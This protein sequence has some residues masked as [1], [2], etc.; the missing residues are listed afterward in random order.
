MTSGLRPVFAL[1]LRAL[2]DELRSR[3]PPFLR[4]AILL[5]LLA[6][7]WM[8]HRVLD[9]IQSAGGLYLLQNLALLNLAGITI[10]GLATFCSA[11]TE[12][13]EDGTLALLRMT[14]LNPLA[15]LLGKSTARFTSGLLFLSVQIPFTLLCVTL[16]GVSTGQIASVYAV[17]I[18]CLF[19]LCNLGL[20]FSVIYRGTPRAV[21]LTIFVCFVLFLFAPFLWNIRYRPFSG[22]TPELSK[23]FLG[24]IT[25]YLSSVNPVTDITNLL[26]NFMYSPSGML[27]T[28]TGPWGRT[29]PALMLGSNSL[30]FLLVTGTTCFLAA[31]ALFEKC[32]GGEVAEALP[33]QPSSGRKRWF[34]RLGGRGGRAWRWPLIWKDFHFSTG[35]WRGV[36]I[37]LAIYIAALGSALWWGWEY[38]YGP[39]L[40]QEVGSVGVYGGG[41]GFLIE[42]AL[43]SAA[44]FGSERKQHT[45]GTL[46]TIP[47]SVRRL[48]WGK[49]AGYALG[50]LLSAAV[51]GIGWML[52]G[53][54]G[55][56]DGNAA[57]LA[58]ADHYYY[59]VQ[60]VFFPVLIA[61]LS[62][63][64]RRGALFLG[65]VSFVVWNIVVAFLWRFV[66]EDR[67]RYLEEGE[68]AAGMVLL[69]WVLS[70][71]LLAAAIFLAFRIPRQ[72][73]RCAAED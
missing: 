41:A 28:A 47:F 6:L 42:L 63:R 14:R 2:R 34:S 45:L 60:L 40:W 38:F 30:A 19:F 52:A 21:I 13:K 8:N 23:S 9:T 53:D 15:I 24:A 3:F 33:R 26:R 16:G 72:L 65:L 25:G 58:R 64:I 59:A 66:F 57:R 10:L 68:Y 62:L 7:L 39:R 18:G 27:P 5:I 51:Y 54:P 20:L 48:V 29:G 71:L 50:L 37:R 67:R 22:T 31:W 32:C 4:T 73:A 46:C 44:L 49:I 11:I 55:F 56:P 36:W 43:A 35:G 61:F 69:P 70:F 17:L 1:F 12:E